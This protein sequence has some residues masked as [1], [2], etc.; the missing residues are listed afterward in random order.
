MTV[1]CKYLTNKNILNMSS[2]LKKE[3]MNSHLRQSMSQSSF[4]Q[5]LF[6]Q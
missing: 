2:I 4:A 1:K 5:L 6:V 3:K